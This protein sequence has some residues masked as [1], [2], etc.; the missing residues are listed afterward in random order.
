MKRK[1]EILKRSGLVLTL[2][3]MR[4]PP[5]WQLRNILRHVSFDKYVWI[6]DY[7]FEMTPGAM[8]SNG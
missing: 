1:K 7:V 4:E 5:K 6:R 3:T 8:N 2:D